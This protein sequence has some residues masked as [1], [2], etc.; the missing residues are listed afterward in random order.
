M[1]EPF[2]FHF[3]L[4]NGLIYSVF[5]TPEALRDSLRVAEALED[6][7]SVN[8]TFDHPPLVQALHRM[9]FTFLEDLAVT[10]DL[11]SAA[12][13]LFATRVRFKCFNLK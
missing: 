12:A 9:Q 11:A 10:S 1:S 7:H 6:F 3:L 5:D 4:V 2:V 8:Q 13:L